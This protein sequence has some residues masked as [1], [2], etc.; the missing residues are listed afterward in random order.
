MRR[1]MIILLSILFVSSLVTIKGTEAAEQYPVKPIMS[2]IPLEAGSGLDILARPLLQK[3]SDILGQPVVVVNKPGGGS[4]IGQR[5]LH[6]AKPDGYT[7]GNTGGVIITNKLQGLLPYDY[8]DYTILGVYLNWVPVLIA[9]T[10]TSRPFSTVEDVIAFAKSKPGE[11]SIA[12]GSVGQIW[13]IATMAFAKATGLGFN[14]I[15]QAAS[16]G[17]T[18]VQVAGGHTD[19]GITDLA[20]SKSQIEAGNVRVLAILGSQ[21]IPGDYGNVRTLKEVGYEVNITSTHLVF[22]PP[23]IPKDITQ[24]LVK[25][26]ELAANDPGYRKYIAGQYAAPLYL[27]PDQAIRLFDDQRKTMRDIMEKAGILKEK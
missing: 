2:M 8:R 23:N 6:G 12:T 26:F 24:K 3:A 20:A 10:R 7:I 11:L 13:W 9:S 18:A 25:T 21:R 4:S 15:P 27:P 1:C 5:E 14:I 19:L 22:G 17:V 16:S